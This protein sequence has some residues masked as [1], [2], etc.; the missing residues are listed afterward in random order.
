VTCDCLRLVPKWF[1]GANQR[2]EEHALGGERGQPDCSVWRRALREVERGKEASLGMT[3]V[4]EAKSERA[5][6][7]VSPFRTVH[8]LVCVEQSDGDSR[9]VDQAFLTVRLTPRLVDGATEK[10]AIGWILKRAAHE[11]SGGPQ[12]RLAR[13]GS[14]VQEKADHVR[15]RLFRSLAESAMRLILGGYPGGRAAFEERCDRR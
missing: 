10:P 13:R 12:G 7:G 9:L 15:M 4:G 6:R 2:A 8:D 11:R 3:Q 5:V 1:T 14:A